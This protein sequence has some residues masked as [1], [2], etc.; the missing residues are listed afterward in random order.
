MKSYKKIITLVLI[1]VLA[2]SALT[3][4]MFAAASS[5]SATVT[6]T[7]DKTSISSGE[8]VTLTVNVTTNFYTSAFAVPVFYDA[9]KFDYVSGSALLSNA[10]LVN[11]SSADYQR[12]FANS[13]LSQSTYGAVGAVFIAKRGNTLQKF[14]GTA[15]FTFTLRAK[16]DASGTALI[17]CNP[18]TKKT[19]SAPEGMLYFGKNSSGT[20][21]LDSLAQNVEKITT[22][23]TNKTITITS[24]NPVINTVGNTTVDA[25]NKVIIIAPD[26]VSAA[27]LSNYFTVVNGSFTATGS[28]TKDTVT[29]K[30]SS[31]AVYAT[32]TLV[33]KGDVNG[34]GSRT[35]E[36][37][38]AVK[39]SISNGTELDN[40][41]TTYYKQAA[42]F[43][44]DTAVDAF[45]MFYLGKAMNGLS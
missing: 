18:K 14:N 38:T 2:A 3:I 41:G 22:S 35:L 24:G 9:S 10:S 44:S 15:V 1:F 25:Q 31:G 11:S 5:D 17:F 4:G 42:D 13:G 7:A 28:G 40:D 30:N 32:Y 6:I 39:L 27:S 23:G 33:V 29:V 45:D 36:D 21:K 34:D 16:S 26:G 37:Y 12:L 43:D 8:I 20:S 19:D